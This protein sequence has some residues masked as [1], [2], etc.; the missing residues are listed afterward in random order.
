MNNKPINAFGHRCEKHEILDQF[1][2]E[3]R[4][5]WR[6]KFTNGFGASII[7]K[8]GSKIYDIVVIGENGCIDPDNQLTCGK[9]NWLCVGE[10]GARAFLN[11]ISKLKLSGSGNENNNHNS[12]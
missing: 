11:R 6:F 7:R 5:K 9:P 2:E 3:Q 8:K 12:N 10:I 1:G 4:Y